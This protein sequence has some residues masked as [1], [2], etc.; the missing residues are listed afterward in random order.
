MG[1]DRQ[2]MPVEFTDLLT[3]SQTR[4]LVFT[5]LWFIFTT[6]TGVARLSLWKGR[7]HTL[8]LSCPINP[9]KWPVN[10][11]LMVLQIGRSPP[12]CGSLIFAQILISEFGQRWFKE[13]LKKQSSPA[14]WVTLSFVSAVCYRACLQER[15][16]LSF[17]K[18]FE[19]LCMYICMHFRVVWLSHESW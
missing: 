19:K 17:I 8:C 15:G 2:D 3:L 12:W 6:S 4:A 16:I 13:V 1:Q 7:M 18:A 9:T 11:R 5:T 10:H 14:Q